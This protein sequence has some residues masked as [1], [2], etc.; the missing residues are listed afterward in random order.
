M[1]WRSLSNIYEGQSRGEVY[2]E[3]GADTSSAATIPSRTAM[4]PEL[5]PMPVCP[6]ENLAGSSFISLFIGT[7]G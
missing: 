6:M 5:E 1:D 4:P 7:D 3:P 2:R